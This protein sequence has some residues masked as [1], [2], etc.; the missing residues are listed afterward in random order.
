MSS[1]YLISKL[2]KWT[3]RK[4][5]LY[6]FHLFLINKS[7]FIEGI[8]EYLEDEQ[9]STELLE[10]ISPCKQTWLD[11]PIKMM[12]SMLEDLM[13]KVGKSVQFKNKKKVWQAISSN[14]ELNG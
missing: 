9:T 7:Y 5:F 8:I 2:K 1:L 11:A 14:L 10:Y 12:L 13:P 3:V 6:I 4:M